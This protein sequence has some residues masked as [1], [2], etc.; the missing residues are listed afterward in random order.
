MNSKKKGNVFE[1]EMAFRLREV[2][3][4]CRT[5]RFMG[6]LWLDSLKVDLTETYPYS[7]Q[8][9]ATEHTPSYHQIL[10]EMPQNGNINCILHKRNNKGTVA[11]MKLDDFLKLIEKWKNYS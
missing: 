1:T 10:S 8:C 2:F 4:N 5:A 11:V 7:F 6:R 3:P 9:K